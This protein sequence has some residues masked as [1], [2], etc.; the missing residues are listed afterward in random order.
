[1]P[2]GNRA[3]FIEQAMRQFTEQR[4]PNKELVVVYDHPDD[5]PQDL[6]LPPGVRLIHSINRSIGSKRN[7]GS[8][9]A[10]GTYI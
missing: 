10:Q 8:Y 2:T 5:L 7:E 1:M 3:G 9:Y 6:V 4:Y